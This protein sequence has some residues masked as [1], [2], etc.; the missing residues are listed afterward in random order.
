MIKNELFANYYYLIFV[1][2]KQPIIWYGEM[3]NQSFDHL[4][5]KNFFHAVNK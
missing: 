2:S 3:L 1:G 4:F 5:P